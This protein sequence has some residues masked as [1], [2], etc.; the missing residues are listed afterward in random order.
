VDRVSL[1]RTSGEKYVGL[2]NAKVPAG[3]Y[4]I[5]I[6]ASA[7][8]ISKTFSDVLELKVVE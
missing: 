6:Q 4:R 5:S 7:S 1:L 8:D 2:W 3:V